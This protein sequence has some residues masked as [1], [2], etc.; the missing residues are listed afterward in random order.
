MTVSHALIISIGLNA[1][2]TAGQ[3][4][5][6]VLSHSLAVA[7]DAAHQFVDVVALT[8][9]YVSVR[10]SARPPTPK[11]TY[12]MRR[13]DSI[14]ALTS[15]LLLLL[16]VGWIAVEALRRL[17][18]PQAVRPGPMIAIGALGVAVNGM[19]AFLVHRSAEPDRK[20]L[21]HS[22]H[23]HSGHDHSLST[24]AARLHL[25][26]DALGSLVVLASGVIITYRQLDRIDPIASLVLCV[27][28]VP[29]A[30]RLVRTSGDVL[31]DSVPAHLDSA[32]ICAAIEE[33]HG[34]RN[35][36]HVHIW[37]LGLGMHA[38]SAHVE[39][40]G[41]ATVHATQL[42]IDRLN[43]ALS[44]NFGIDHT[45]LQIECHPC[46]DPTHGD[47]LQSAEHAN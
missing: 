13:S 45:T 31:M 33:V 2:L 7:A 1:T 35:V 10:A 12:G 42:I 26:T 22:G 47:R 37:S 32:V 8:I 43:N 38:L 6:G 23:D 27:L 14:S 28:I 19:S 36:H 15:S 29:A 46:E 3:I 11:R 20:Q 5:V 9:A 25:V 44:T 34:V 16:S 4:I 30:L 41:E 21:G 40:D 24:R 18:A 39:V 17:A